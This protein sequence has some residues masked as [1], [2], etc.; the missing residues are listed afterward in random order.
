MITTHSN[1]KDTCKNKQPIVVKQAMAFT[2][3]TVA[4][5][6]LQALFRTFFPEGALTPKP[7]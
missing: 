4:D 6:K 1:N 5:L 2:R 7:N 3:P